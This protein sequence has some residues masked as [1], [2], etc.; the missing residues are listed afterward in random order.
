MIHLYKVQYRSPNTETIQP[1]IGH[2]VVATRGG[3]DSVVEVV[4]EEYGVAITIMSIDLF[5]NVS[6][7]LVDTRN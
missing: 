7:L 1:R 6:K 4:K 2:C 3:I 5:A